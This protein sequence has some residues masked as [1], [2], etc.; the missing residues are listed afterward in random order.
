MTLQEDFYLHQLGTAQAKSMYIQMQQELQRGNRSGIFCLTC[1]QPKAAAE[2]AFQAYTA[3]RRDRPE[4]FFLGSKLHET[5]SGRF[6]ELRSK[7]QY[8]PDQIPRI[9]RQISLFLEKLTS[10]A[11]GNTSWEMERQI[12]S[13]LRRLL[14]YQKTGHSYEHDIV[15]PTLS[16]AGVC[17]GFSSLFVLAMRHVGIPCIRIDGYGR[18]ERHTWNVVWI[19]GCPCHVDL[20]WDFV[21][22]GQVAYYYFNQPDHLMA[23][24][25]T[26]DVSKIPICPKNG[27]SYPEVAG[28]D[29][30]DPASA[31]LGLRQMIQNGSSVIRFNCIDASAAIRLFLKSAPEGK[32]RYSVSNTNHSGIVVNKN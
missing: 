18:K 17:D 9:E 12:Y 31:A 23:Q 21:C 4:Y 5:V 25:H 14:S 20:T 10:P 13:K 30:S 16:Y 11:A 27:I 22:D 1:S 2:D 8:Y 24:D 15:G 28:T 26:W 6:V 32:Y 29:Y 3:L 19:E 7:P